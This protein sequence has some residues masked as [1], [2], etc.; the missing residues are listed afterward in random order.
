MCCWLLRASSGNGG[1]AM[2]YPGT[3]GSS[4]TGA[5]GKKDAGS[6]GIDP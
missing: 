4:D 1:R 2:A 6:K 5:A 3:V